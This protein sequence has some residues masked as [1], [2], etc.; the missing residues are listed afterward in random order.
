M[1]ETRVSTSKRRSRARKKKEAPPAPE[2]A[3]EKASAKR[4]GLLTVATALVSFAAVIAQLSG[5]NPNTKGKAQEFKSFDTGLAFAATGMK[6]VSMLMLIGV[7]WFLFRAIQRR[8]PTAPNYVLILGIVAVVFVA[9]VSVANAVSFN[10]V[11]NEFLDLP[12]G[13]QTNDKADDLLN[14]N[15]VSRLGLVLGYGSAAV[16]GAWLVILCAGAIG[17][18]LMPRYLGYFGYGTAAMGILAGPTGG[19]F[20]VIWIVAVALLMLDQWPGGRPR[21]WETGR[22]EP[23]AG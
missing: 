4:F 19:A 8:E 20:L 1:S 23:L 10:S 3:A 6:V 16:F 18:G 13:Q 5:Q 7:G 21:S 9:L 14:D 11:V 15:I 17:V 12:S 22:A 2:A